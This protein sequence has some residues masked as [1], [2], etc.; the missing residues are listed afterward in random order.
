MG[1]SDKAKEL[2]CT[3][4]GQYKLKKMLSLFCGTMVI[5]SSIFSLL[6]VFDTAFNLLK[7]IKILW[8]MVFGVLMLLHEF[9][10]TTCAPHRPEP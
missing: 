1:V 3:W 5:L 10:V 4:D 6:D 2:C 9:K 7:T 8:N